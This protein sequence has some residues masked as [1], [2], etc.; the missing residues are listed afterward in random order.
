MIEV[1]ETFCYM[2]LVVVGSAFIM[3]LISDMIGD[4]TEEEKEEKR[5]W[6]ELPS[7]L[8]DRDYN[9]YICCPDQCRCFNPPVEL[10][11]AEE[12]EEELPCGSTLPE[13]FEG[14]SL[15]DVLDIGQVYETVASREGVSCKPGAGTYWMAWIRSF[16]DATCCGID[17]LVAFEK[18]PPKQFVY[19]LNGEVI[20]VYGNGL[21]NAG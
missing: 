17:Q 8:E 10:P 14:V 16:E 5:T 18:K 19:A 9:C 7:D 11:L 12:C 6:V 2:V 1:I 4:D 13:H 20:E 15:G 3:M 21:R